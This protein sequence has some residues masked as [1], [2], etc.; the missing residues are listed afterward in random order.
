MSTQTDPEVIPDS[1]SVRAGR[2]LIS[3]ALLLALGFVAYN[4]YFLCAQ[5][6]LAYE[7]KLREIDHLDSEIAVL[8]QQNSILDQRVSY[9]RTDA[10]VEEVAREKLGLVRPGEVAFVVVPA[11]AADLP[12]APVYV[13]RPAPRRP[14]FVQRALHA[15]FEPGFPK[16]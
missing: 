11:L 15:I 3:L 7:Q 8:K 12:D 6:Q 5:K 16:P 1:P 4:F 2:S 9:L 14:S 13:P 10:G